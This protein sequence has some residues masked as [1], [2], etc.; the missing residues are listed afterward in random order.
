MDRTISL[1]DL[2]HS[3]KDCVT[4]NEYLEK[5]EIEQNALPTI[6]LPALNKRF[7]V[8]VDNILQKFLMPVMLGKQKTQMNQSIYYDVIQITE[9]QYLVEIR[10]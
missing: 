6:G 7:F 4:N 3:I 9:W 10:I 1:C 8:Q 5:F 2:L